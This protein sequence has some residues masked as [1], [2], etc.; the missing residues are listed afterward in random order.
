[1]SESPTAVAEALFKQRR[2]KYHSQNISLSDSLTLTQ[3]RST[4]SIEILNRNMQQ[5]SSFSIFL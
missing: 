5:N 2:E 4:L 1:M 3:N